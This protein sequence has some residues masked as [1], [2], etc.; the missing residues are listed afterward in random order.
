ME[1]EMNPVI[2]ELVRE[3]G[4]EAVRDALQQVLRQEI[5]A[6]VAEKFNLVPRDAEGVKTNNN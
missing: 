6:N 4:Y 1:M 3:H 5:L 2:R